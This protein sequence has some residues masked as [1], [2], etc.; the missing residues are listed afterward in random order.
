M[1]VTNINCIK[2]TSII[3]MVTKVVAK[4]SMFN[5]VDIFYSHTI[6]KLFKIQF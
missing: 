1:S 6:G 5:T 4:A 3:T 2:S